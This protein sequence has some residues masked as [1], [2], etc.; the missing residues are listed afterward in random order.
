[1]SPAMAQ[2]RVSLLG[3]DM[4]NALTLMLSIDRDLWYGK[5]VETAEDMAAQHALTMVWSRSQTTARIIQME[6]YILLLVSAE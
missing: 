2:T 3:G 1:M 6:G 5:H 4:F